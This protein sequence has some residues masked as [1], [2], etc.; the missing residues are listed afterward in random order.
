MVNSPEAY[1]VEDL[2]RFVMLLADWHTQK[3][4]VLKHMLDVPEGTE[5][6]FN[7]EPATPLEG[8]KLAGFRLGLNL[9]LMELGNLPFIYEASKDDAPVH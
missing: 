1:V 2:D 3:V 7:D 5:V 4:G 8:A 6:S 9:A